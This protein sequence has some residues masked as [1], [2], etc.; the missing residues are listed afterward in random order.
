M[1]TV[2][3]DD[4]ARRLRFIYL[5]PQSFRWPAASI[6]AYFTFAGLAAAALVAAW[7]TRPNLGVFLLFEIPGAIGGSILVTRSVFRHVNADMPLSYQLRTFVAE[8]SGPRPER[9]TT[10]T[11]AIDSRVFTDFKGK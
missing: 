3:T 11:T 2:K 1:P 9:G 5:G 7:V 10:T 8:L 6:P 4:A